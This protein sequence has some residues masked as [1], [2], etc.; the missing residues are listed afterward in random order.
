MLIAGLRRR[1]TFGGAA[2]SISEQWED[3]ARLAPIPD[4]RG[5]TTYGV[6]CATDLPAQSFEYMSG[7]EVAAFE[8]LP[9]GLGRM[10][11]PAQRYAVFEHAGHVSTL[12][13]TWGAIWHDWVPRSG[14]KPADTPDFELYGERFDPATGTGVVEIWFPVESG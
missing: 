3:F 4:R 7:A 10:R 13:E 11:V 8:A 14:I 6:M 5:A 12:R 1:H 2:R 9:I